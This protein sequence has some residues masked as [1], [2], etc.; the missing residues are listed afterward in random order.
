MRTNADLSDPKCG[1]F[2]ARNKP[3]RKAL[4]V[5]GYLG[6]LA[7]IVGIYVVFINQHDPVKTFNSITETTGVVVLVLGVLLLVIS[8]FT[9]RRLFKR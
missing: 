9:V 7:I 4:I 8:A 6:L 5:L 3:I 2:G 1:P